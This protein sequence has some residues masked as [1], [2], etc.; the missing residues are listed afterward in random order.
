M[1]F[2][3][4]PD[5]GSADTVDGLIERLRLLKI[6]AGDPSYEWIKDQVNTAWGTTGRPPNCP[7]RPRSWTASGPAGDG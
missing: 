6:W 5:P 3:D 1:P 7:A 4:P 2:K